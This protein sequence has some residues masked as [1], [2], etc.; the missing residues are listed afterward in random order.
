MYSKEATNHNYSDSP[1][2]LMRKYILAVDFILQG[3]LEEHYISFLNNLDEE[4]YAEFQE[5]ISEIIEEFS[6]SDEEIEKAAE[7]LIKIPVVS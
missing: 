1:L 5:E 3:D 4:E 2:K 6:I 7:K